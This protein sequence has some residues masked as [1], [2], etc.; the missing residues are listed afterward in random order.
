MDNKII[1]DLQSAH[2]EHLRKLTALHESEL[3]R[4]AVTLESL[5]TDSSALR[6]END[7][8]GG[9]VR[10]LRGEVEGTRDDFD[11]I[12]ARL[13]K[14]I[15]EE[16]DLVELVRQAAGGD[17]KRLDQKYRDP[18]TA[19]TSNTSNTSNSANPESA[20][21]NM[22][23]D[24][25]ITKYLKK[26]EG[27]DPLHLCRFLQIPFNPPD[28]PFALSYSLLTSIAAHLSDDPT[29]KLNQPAREL[30]KEVIKVKLEVNDISRCFL[31]NSRIS[32]KLAVNGDVGSGERNVV[33]WLI[34]EHNEE[35]DNE[36][37]FNPA[38]IISSFSSLLSN[39]K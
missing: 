39:F 12:Q 16:D 33:R 24:R 31:K 4:L 28:R 13:G 9:L 1:D 25:I 10:E 18:S 11:L 35:R 14:I 27:S 15:V 3:A 5:R 22:N 29:T 23:Q 37:N 34:H 6:K 17:A 20:D 7:E 2:Q 8:L 30:L 38:T 19:N 32:G 26:I 36:N 21:M